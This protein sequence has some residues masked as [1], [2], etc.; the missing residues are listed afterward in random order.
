MNFVYSPFSTATVLLHIANATITATQSR[1]NLDDD[2]EA[3]L[4]NCA[5]KSTHLYNLKYL[6]HLK[7]NWQTPHNLE[8]SLREKRQIEKN[9]LKEGLV[10][11]LLFNFFLVLLLLLLKID[12]YA[13]V[14]VGGGQLF[15]YKH[16]QKA[17]SY[18]II[19]RLL[20][21]LG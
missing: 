21:Q 6:A 13:D 20:S 17:G 5:L 8:S 10:A 3:S 14:V 2:S 16:Y 4:A 7:Q 1:S 9:E 19:R 11:S 12:Y 15:D 18:S